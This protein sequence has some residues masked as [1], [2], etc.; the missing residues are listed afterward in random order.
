MT[1]AEKLKNARKNAGMSQEVL[2][3]KLGVSR[4]AV[5][6]WE[7][8]RGIPDTE[9][10]IVISNLFGISVDEFLSQEKETALRKGYLYESRTEYDIDGKKRFD[11]KLGGASVLTVKGIEGEKIVVRLMSNEIATLEEDFK[12]KIDDVRGRIDVDINRK[13]KMTEATA[14]ESLLIEVLLPIKYLYHVEL[15]S[16]CD[17]LYL[18]D[19]TCEHVEFQGKANQ[20]SLE[21]IA[22]KLELDCNVDMNIRAEK[23][24][25]SLEINQISSTS[26]LRVPADFSFKSVVKGISTSVS[27]EVDGKV[28]EDFSDAGADNVVEFNGMKSELVIYRAEGEK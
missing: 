13:N 28:V 22:A 9:N 12:V 23:F 26:R 4:Q 2:A 8:E 1:F 18:C 19:L 6:K 3:E 17:E 7:T 20:V 10:M 5:T 14:K 16:L 25:G 21:S 24:A 27:Y 11:M 15:E